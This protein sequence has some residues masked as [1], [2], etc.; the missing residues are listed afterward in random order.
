MAKYGPKPRPIAERLWERVDKTKGCW[1]WTGATI[2]GY[3]VIKTAGRM[4]RVH[5]LAYELEVGPIPQELTLDHLCRVRR[6]VRPSH[7][8]AVTN[9][10]NSLRGIGPSA[11]NARKTH[12]QHGHE[13]TEANIYITPRGWRQCRI[14]LRRAA[15]RRRRRV[16]DARLRS[17]R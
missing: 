6:C 17:D 11:Q 9:R 10:E 4:V 7:L 15:R 13:L 3:G 8:E 1:L 5:R 16:A 14:C 2:F 12:C